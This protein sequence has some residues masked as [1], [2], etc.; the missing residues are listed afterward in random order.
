MSE[1]QELAFSKFMKGSFDRVRQFGKPGTPR[2]R[3]A[4]DEAEFIAY[5]KRQHA[6]ERVYYESRLDH[7]DAEESLAD[8]EY[9][10]RFG[11]APDGFWRVVADL[12]LECDIARSRA[13]QAK[14]AMKLQRWGDDFRFAEKNLRA[15]LAE[16]RER[17]A[18]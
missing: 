13:E 10:M 7:M 3:E 2:E 16:K 12:H 5:R 11:D 14:A 17:E 1:E 4:A 18:K 6:A 9:S 8:A 15:F